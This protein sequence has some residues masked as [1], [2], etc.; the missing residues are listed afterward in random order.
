V[1]L[2]AA[3]CGALPKPFKSVSGG[4]A[5][6]PLAAMRDSAGIVVAPIQGAPPA[7]AG[8]LA[9]IMAA[10]FRRA[11][12]P[13]TTGSAIKNAY[14]LEGAATFSGA[15]G[16]ARGGKETVSIAWAVSDHRGVGIESFSTEHK[17]TAAAWRVG[18]RAR[19]DA[20]AAA[21]APRIA[22]ML[23]ANLP[24]A[25]ETPPPMIGIIAIEGAPG[26]G[27]LALKK[28]FETVL[29]D[30]GVPVTADPDLA[31]IRVF[32]KVA[33]A[34]QSE[35]RDKITIIWTL[36]NLDGDEIGVLT[37]N[38]TIRK[39]QASA[40]WGPLAYDVTFAMVDSIA[41]ILRTMNRADDITRR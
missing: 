11:N 9:E 33:I 24:A 41:N 20:I 4:G 40:R 2:I 38:N 26:D 35:T 10:T 15:P 36:R 18:E 28:A 1:I 5:E 32:G 30:A 37:Q 22:A 31:T 19:L 7:V 39:G 6:N 34:T 3:G 12:I 23:R 17:I 16:G 27:N 8:P 25:P 14:L 13:A 29:R 21:T